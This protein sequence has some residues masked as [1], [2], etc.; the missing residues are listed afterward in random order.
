MPNYAHELEKEP[1]DEDKTLCLKCSR[2]R[3]QLC[4]LFD[5]Q[6]FHQI[7]KVEWSLDGLFDSGSA[8]KG[9]DSEFRGT[10]SSLVGE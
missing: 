10:T 8:F 3:I 7:Q 2:E 4:G 6:K 9:I 5:E 1:R